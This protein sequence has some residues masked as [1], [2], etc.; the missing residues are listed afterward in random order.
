M[1]HGAETLSQHRG[2]GSCQ[3]ALFFESVLAAKFFQ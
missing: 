1:A 3:A 2:I